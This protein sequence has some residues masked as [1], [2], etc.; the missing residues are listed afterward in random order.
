M[1]WSTQASTHRAFLSKNL[2]LPFLADST[3]HWGAIRKSVRT[4]FS[5]ARF[6]SCLF[7]GL[8][9][10]SGCST[11]AGT[12]RVFLSKIR[13]LPFWRTQPVTGVRYAS[14]WTRPVKIRAALRH[15][16]LLHYSLFIIH[17]K[18]PG[19]RFFPARRAFLFSFSLFI[20]TSI[21]PCSILS[22]GQSSM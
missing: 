7:G 16:L 4:G 8:D 18:L 5:S 14:R 12:H 2:H 21:Y 6:A 15:T 3:G 19:G 17:S 13:Q 1:G 20:L 10:S 22:H 9:R 11:Q